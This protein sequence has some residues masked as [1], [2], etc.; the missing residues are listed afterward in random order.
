MTLSRNPLAVQ[1]PWFGTD[2][3]D[4]KLGTLGDDFLIGL[5][6]NDTLRGLA[7]DDALNGQKG[8][9][10][11]YGGAGKD[12]IYASGGD[13]AWGGSGQDD[14][15]FLDR[16]RLPDIT[17]PGVVRIKDF[18]A[19]GADHDRMDISNFA[20]KWASRDAGLEDGFEMVKSGANVIL[21]LLGDDG[22]I[23][24]VV[25]ENTKLADLDKGDFF[26]GA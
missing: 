25:L 16:D 6:G 7:G 17:D 12:R 4:K 21:R 5:G 1:D 22:S 15:D 20:T 8:A 3:A 10:Q 23:T 19:R 2:D 24:K 14:F 26:F 18:D 13:Q 11:L 9:D